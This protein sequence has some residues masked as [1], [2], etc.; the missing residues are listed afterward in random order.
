[1]IYAFRLNYL[2]SKFLELVSSKFRN[3]PI[4]LTPLLSFNLL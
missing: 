1:M 4:K 2:A 3:N